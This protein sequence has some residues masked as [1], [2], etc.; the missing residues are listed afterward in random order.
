MSSW[1]P[2][3]VVGGEFSSAGNGGM[4]VEPKFHKR[5]GVGRFEIVFAESDEGFLEAVTLGIGRRVR[6]WLPDR[7][8]R[9]GAL[10]ID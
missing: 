3:I 5:I 4:A 9:P 1:L 7:R 8:C 2:G 6:G 10:P